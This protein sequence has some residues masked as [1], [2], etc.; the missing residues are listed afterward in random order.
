MLIEELANIFASLS[1]L[2]NKRVSAKDQPRPPLP[3][4]DLFLSHSSP[5]QAPLF[6][7]PTA[8]IENCAHIK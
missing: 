7:L 2:L 8:L 4:S 5:K 1:I 6:P 3:C